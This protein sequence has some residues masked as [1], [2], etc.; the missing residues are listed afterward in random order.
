MVKVTAAE[1]QIRA[2]LD[3]TKLI[4]P[5][6]PKAWTKLADASDAFVYRPARLAREV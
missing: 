3:L 5:K 2:R 1:S 4:R 6:P